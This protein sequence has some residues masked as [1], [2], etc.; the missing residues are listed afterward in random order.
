MSSSS[1]PCPVCETPLILN[2]ANAGSETACPGC[3]VRLKLPDQADSLAPLTIVRKAAAPLETPPVPPQ[4]TGGGSALPSARTKSSDDELRRLAGAASAAGGAHSFTPEEAAQL[5]AERGKTLLPSRR[6]A[7]LVP[8]T[9]AAR[10]EP[11]PPA[12]PASAPGSEPPA[13]APVAPLSP[14]IHQQVD[15]SP[16]PLVG[17]ARNLPQ[18]PVA[19]VPAPVSAPA[20]E[21]APLPP[22]ESSTLS[23]E[24]EAEEAGSGKTNFRLNQERTPQF[25][26][27]EII[28]TDVDA[29]EWG[30]EQTPQETART[31]RLVTIALAVMLLIAGGVAVYVTRQAFTPPT[32]DA[33]TVEEAEDPM[34][35]VEGARATMKRF[36]AAT[37][38]EQMAAEVR[39]PE[40]T[41]ARMERF[42]SGKK[43]T[44]LTV[45]TESAAWGEAS[46]NERNFISNTMELSDFDIRSVS[47]ELFADGPPKVDWESFV[48]WSEIP[49]ADYLSHPPDDAMEFRVSATQDD[50]YTGAFEGREFDMLCFKLR[51][52]KKS[53]YEFCYGYCDKNSEVG[54]QIAFMQRRAR[55]ARKVD[56]KGKP[57]ANCILRLR[58]SPEGKKFNQVMIEKMVFQGWVQP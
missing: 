34:K 43:I 3:G 13:K 37:T 40:E 24:A 19:P 22:A 18:A 26:P 23:A 46:I 47:L 57:L 1:L 35:N 15:M 10:R 36:L 20:A 38:I 49:W 16:T 12:A 27:Q 54:T 33:R 32:N 42:Y 51:S 56:E 2:E 44:P 55:Q 17:G 9:G 45:R 30:G 7:D 8:A 25:V 6:S 50:F 4:P 28:D 21:T 11:Q 39:H 29:K 52:P 48:N 53:Q 58:F 31:R 14:K 41:K 5:A